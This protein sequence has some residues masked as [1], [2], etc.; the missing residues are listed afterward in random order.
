[1]AF[2]PTLAQLRAFAAVV[3]HQGFSRAA[4]ALG[5]TQS[6]LSHSVSSLEQGLNAVL[7]TRHARGITLTAAGNGVYHR[8][9]TI[10]QLTEQL[11]EE[12]AGERTLSGTVSIACYRSVATH[13][14]PVVLLRIQHLHPGIRLTISDGCLEREDASREVLMGRSQLGIAHLPAD[15]RLQA[16]PIL[17]DPYVLV[18]PKGAAEVHRWEDLQGMP[19]IRF[20]REAHPDEHAW[21]HLHPQLSLQEESSILAMV[22]SGMGFSVLPRLTTEPHP[23]GVRLQSL[24]TFAARTLGVVTRSETLLLPEVR[25]VLDLLC[26]PEVLKQST[27]HQG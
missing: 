1:M 25:A 11:V 9:R 23:P 7:L 21:S 6:S 8:V 4:A 2:Q 27:L 17:T 3:D 10:L 19:F 20:G 15:P 22:A 26:D 13:L 16:F 12:S 14:L 18:L 5:V 24:P